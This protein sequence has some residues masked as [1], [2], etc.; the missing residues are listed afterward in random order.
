MRLVAP[1]RR[2]TRPDS[3]VLGCVPELDLA[4][5]PSRDQLTSAIWRV[6]KGGR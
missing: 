1:P 5:Q 6:Y 4:L 2:V 3:A